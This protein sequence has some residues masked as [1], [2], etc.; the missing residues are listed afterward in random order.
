MLCGVD[1]RSLMLLALCQSN[2][3]FTLQPL[4][5]PRS[6]S[7]RASHASHGAECLAGKQHNTLRMDRRFAR[8]A[9]PPPP[10]LDAD[11]PTYLR[12]YIVECN[13]K[14]CIPKHL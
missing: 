4:P 12:W 1:D 8:F 3:A 14:Y 6:A 10:R 9:P 2:A 11:L 7:I 5:T 13:S